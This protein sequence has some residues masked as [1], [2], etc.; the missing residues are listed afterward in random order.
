MSINNPEVNIAII[1][2]FI[3]ALS[4]EQK[5]LYVGQKTAAGT[6]TAGTLVE[7]IGNANE[8]DTLFGI[9]SMLAGMVRAGKKYNKTTQ[10]DAIV[11]DD[12]GGG[13]KAT[14]TFAITGPATADGT[15]SFVVGSRKNHTYSVDVTSGDTAT[16]I[17]DA[18]VALIV[19]DTKSPFSSANVTGTVTITAANDGLIANFFGLEV[20][21]SETLAGVAVVV[22]AM[23][24]GTLDPVLT[25]V[26]AL[27]DNIKYQT[28][29]FP[30]TYLDQAVAVDFLNDR[31]NTG[32]DKLLDGV[33]IAFKT[34]TFANLLTD[35]TAANSQNYV[36]FSNRKVDKTGYRGSA[37]SEIN[38]DLASQFGSVRGLR[39]TPGTDIS[40]F[41][42]SSGGVND[43]IGGLHISTLPYHET[44]FKNMPIIDTDEMWTDDE[45]DSLKDVGLGIVGNNPA[46]AEIIADD[47]VTRYKT[48]SAG[49]PDLSF[50]FLNYV[51]QSE[52]VRAVF[53]SQLKQAYRQFRLTDGSLPPN[54]SITNAADVRGEVLKIYNEL[55]DQVIV[56]RGTAALKKF[57]DNLV[58]TIDEI[59][60]LITI[61]MLDPVVTQVRKIDVT[62]QLIFSVNS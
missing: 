25:T 14:G 24:G 49:D 1:P 50:K 23:S 41:V 17:G 16:E 58:I 5:I 31:F 29:I 38:Y 10:M 42:T 8:Q 45:R 26:F 27:V 4:E 61:S 6:A 52:T 53:H 40:S 57:K 54:F 28:V 7:K 18:L 43:R 36:L 56:Q 48:D 20:V 11:L 60:G 55:A 13:A 22:T 12:N 44:P 9:D 30:E 19:A 34:E 3:T 37:L 33:G 15:V 51:D 62:M 21:L 2:Q 32:T 47:I 59:Q 46:N 39:L 35:T